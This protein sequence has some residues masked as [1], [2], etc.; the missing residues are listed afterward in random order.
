M[1]ATPPPLP[2]PAPKPQLFVQPFL[3]SRPSLRSFPMVPSSVC[4]FPVSQVLLLSGLCL[5]GMA[6]EQ[7]SCRAVVWRTCFTDLAPFN[8]SMSNVSTEHVPYGIF[9]KA[10]D[11]TACGW[12]FKGKQQKMHFWLKGHTLPNCMDM[13]HLW[14]SKHNTPALKELN[15][16]SIYVYSFPWFCLGKLYFSFTG[17]HK[18]AEQVLVEKTKSGLWLTSRI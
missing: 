12:F 1:P 15:D 14:P 17:S 10:Y 8:S 16:Q 5:N 7:C 3:G 9:S 6:Y 11:L 13:L 2:A 4:S 18:Y